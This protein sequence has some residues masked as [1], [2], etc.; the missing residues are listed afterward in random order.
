MSA[1]LRLLI[2]FIMSLVLHGVVFFMLPRYEP[3][4]RSVSTPIQVELEQHQRQPATPEPIARELPQR[5]EL[6]G[7]DADLLSGRKI[8]LPRAEHPNEQTQEFSVHAT[9]GRLNISE[10]QDSSLERNRRAIPPTPPA[11]LGYVDR[12][13][14]ELYARQQKKDIV[15]VVPEMTSETHDER[16]QILGDLS[17]RQIIFM[18]AFPQV[19]A[20]F[21]TTMEIILLVEPSGSVSQTTIRRR[22]GSEELDR[23]GEEYARRIRFERLPITNTQQGTLIIDFQVLP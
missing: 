9:P 15:D 22:S 23:H 6:A 13:I 11:E 5:I 18:P 8:E 20:D 4:V 1:T 16:V 21:A 12:H 17:R 10:R 3:P 7:R 2:L 14:Q 19:S